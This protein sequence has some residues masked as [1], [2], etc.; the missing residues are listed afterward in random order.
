MAG[1]IGWVVAL[2][3]L[4]VGV[5]LG[6]VFG[7]VAMASYV[8]RHSPRAWEMLHADRAESAAI[9]A[10]AMERDVLDAVEMP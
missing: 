10:F 2:A 9:R 6:V 4:A 8:R 1:W 5:A 7:M 3:V